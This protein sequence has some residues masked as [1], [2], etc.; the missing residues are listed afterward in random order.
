[1]FKQLL[2]VEF[3]CNRNILVLSLLINL[4]CFAVL[5]SQQAVAEMYIVATMFSF[6]ILLSVAAAAAATEKRNRLYMQLPVNAQQIFLTGW[7]FVLIW[8]LLQICA[9]VLYAALFEPEINSVQLMEYASI[10]VGSGL[11]IALISIGI[12][13]GGFRPGYFQWLYIGSVIILFVIAVSKDLSV[14]LVS[15]EEGIRVLP[16]T[17]LIDGVGDLGLAFILMLGAL[18][19]NYLVFRYSDSYLG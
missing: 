11:V 1:M 8:L 18:F 10:G 17:A 12:D 3:R 2:I 7:S 15:G 6:Y 9:W 14:V 19:A 13:L 16:I 4:L 5:G